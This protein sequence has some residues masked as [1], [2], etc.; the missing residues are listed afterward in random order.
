M[1]RLADRKRGG[2]TDEQHIITVGRDWKLGGQIIARSEG[3]DQGTRE[4]KKKKNPKYLLNSGS[5]KNEP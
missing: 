4:T 1:G 2:R 3:T 5:R